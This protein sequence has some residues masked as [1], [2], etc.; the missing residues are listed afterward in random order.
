MGGMT[1]SIGDMYTEMKVILKIF[2]N[3]EKFDF[4]VHRHVRRLQGQEIHWAPPSAGLRIW[5]LVKSSPSLFNPYL[6]AQI[7]G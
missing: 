3:F 1:V 4:S 2:E 6:L 5:N 7:H